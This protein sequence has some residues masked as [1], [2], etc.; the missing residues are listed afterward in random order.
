[1]MAFL[2]NQV[3]VLYFNSKPANISYLSNMYSTG[4]SFKFGI[5]QLV[6]I[7]VVLTLWTQ[8]V[9]PLMGFQSR[10]W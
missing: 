8:Y 9:M 5:T 1:P 4:E 6:L 2:I 7:L 10:L 3:Y